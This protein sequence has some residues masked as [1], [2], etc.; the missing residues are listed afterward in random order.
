MSTSSKIILIGEHSVV[1]GKRAIAIPIKK[2]KLSVNLIDNYIFESEHVKYIKDLIEK[3]FV[4]PKKYIKVSSNIPR[5][6][7]MGSSASLAIE[8]ARAYKVDEKFVVYHA[9]KKKHENP[10]GIDSAVILNEKAIIYQKNKDIEFIKK[11][12]AYIVI[13]NTKEYGS[14]KKA[15]EIVKEKNRSDLID[16]LGKITE[17]AILYYKNRNLVNLGKTFN[18]AQNIL[19]QLGVSTPKIDE[20]VNIAKNYSLGT[21]LSGGGLGGVVISL[22]ENFSSAKNLKKI[23]KQNNIKDIFIVKI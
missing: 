2:L 19:K 15:I 18:L 6:A 4:V 5:S 11:L 14:T 3:N 9:E 7:G 12:N 1:Y 16:D 23:L 22:C 8:I 13:S 17:L 20:I 10:S 21:K